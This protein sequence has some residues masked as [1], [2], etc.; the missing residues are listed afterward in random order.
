MT[1]SDFQSRIRWFS[2]TLKSIPFIHRLPGLSSVMAAMFGDIIRASIHDRDSRLLLHSEAS[3]RSSSGR[4]T[5]FGRES[6]LD[7]R[8]CPNAARHDCMTLN[9]PC[10]CSRKTRIADGDVCWGSGDEGGVGGA[11]G[12]LEV[13][14]LADDSRQ[15]YVIARLSS[16]RKT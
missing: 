13:V 3:S 1:F 14:V 12:G 11:C 9:V 5:S 15:P 16:V 10:R 6:T 8:T 2:P 4:V 7:D